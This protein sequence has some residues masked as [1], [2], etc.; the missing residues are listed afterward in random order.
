MT[1]SSLI[2]FLIAIAAGIGWIRQWRG[3]RHH[4][5]ELLRIDELQRKY[6]GLWEQAEQALR[7]SRNELRE[8][9]LQA[10]KRIGELKEQIK[11]TV[12]NSEALLEAAGKDRQEQEEVFSTLKQCA[13]EY[14]RERL[15]MQE[16][17]QN[18]LKENDTFG[19]ELVALGKKLIQK[20][21]PRNLPVTTT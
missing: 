12:S 6:R 13:E 16:A 15:E 7:D 2:W 17:Y 20:Q 21:E 14:N 9:T 5:S 8:T 10:N 3:D 1:F 18:L 4:R 11:L 19:K